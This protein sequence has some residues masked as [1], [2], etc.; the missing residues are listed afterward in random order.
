MKVRI[1]MTPPLA[2]MDGIQLGNMIPGTVRE[3]SPSIGVWL[4]AE[5]YA[6]LEMREQREQLPR[7]PCAVVNDRRRRNRY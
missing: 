2:E 6:V 7:N 3:V 5:G 1:L 4:V